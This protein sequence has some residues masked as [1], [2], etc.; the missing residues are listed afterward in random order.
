[1]PPQ[2]V[3]FKGTQERTVGPPGGLLLVETVPNLTLHKDAVIGRRCGADLRYRAL[4]LHRYRRR[5]SNPPVS[6]L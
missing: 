6:R 3:Y 1:M 4:A 5:G 2:A